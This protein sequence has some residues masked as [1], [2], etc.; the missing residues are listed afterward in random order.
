MITSVLEKI[1]TISAF[2]FNKEK[3][4]KLSE[5]ELSKVKTLADKTQERFKE[6]IPPQYLKNSQ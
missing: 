1:L 4:E 5:K 6:M 3:L 2:N